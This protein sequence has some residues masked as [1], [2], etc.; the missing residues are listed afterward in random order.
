MLKKIL[1]SDTKYVASGDVEVIDIDIFSNNPDTLKDKYS[2]SQL[3][4]YNEDKQR[5]MY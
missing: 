2:N 3:N 5:Y 1:M 4:Y